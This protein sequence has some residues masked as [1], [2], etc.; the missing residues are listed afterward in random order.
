MKNK[1]RILFSVL[2]IA[3]AGLA[4]SGVYW[5]KTMAERS[6]TVSEI[7]EKNAILA[8]TD[9]SGL[10]SLSLP[11]LTGNSY[12]YQDD[13]CVYYVNMEGFIERIDS[14]DLNREYPT[15][16]SE[17][18]SLDQAQDRAVE[19]F[20]AVFAEQEAELGRNY[21]I[22]STDFNGG[23][24]MVNI[25]LLDGEKQTGNKASISFDGNGELISSMFLRDTT[26]KFERSAE[27]SEEKAK[28][29]ALQY[30]YE[31]YEEELAHAIEPENLKS[32]E[33]GEAE[34]IVLNKDAFWDVEVDAQYENV[35]FE[36]LSVLD[37]GSIRI[38]AKTGEYIWFAS[39]FK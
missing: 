26:N 36:K 4:V 38:D 12:R 39:I 7:K 14:L 25:V 10:V 17:N 31:V 11:G 16:A 20:D 19:L 22:D 32:V 5:N 30:F 2:A 15:Q 23:D 13:S 21:K 6:K 28:E 33:L 27:I 35:G 8:D 18:F 1:K 37:T 9:Y 3:A 34:R 24:Y 29:L